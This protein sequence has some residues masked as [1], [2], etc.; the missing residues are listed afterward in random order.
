MSRCPCRTRTGGRLTTRGGRHAD[1]EVPGGVLAK[2]EAV[3]GGPSANMLDDR[4][5]V[6]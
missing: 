2:L 4:L 3:A 5:L 6:T 1:D